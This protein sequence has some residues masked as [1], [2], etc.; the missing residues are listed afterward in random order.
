MLGHSHADGDGHRP[1]ADAH[2]S[3]ADA[4]PHADFGRQGDRHTDANSDPGRPVPDAEP[5]ADPH[6]NIGRRQG[7]Q[8]DDPGWPIGDAHQQS[9]PGRTN[10][11]VDPKQDAYPDQTAEANGDS[12]LCAIETVPPSRSGTAAAELFERRRR[13]MA[14]AA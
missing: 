11:D 13:N 14:C 12:A 9:N 7:H 1:D 5:H 3:D 8:H 2:R 4:H 6:F 10:H